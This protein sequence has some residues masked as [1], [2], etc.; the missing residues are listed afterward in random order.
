RL[1]DYTRGGGRPCGGGR[2]RIP[3]IS[4]EGVIPLTLQRHQELQHNNDTPERKEKNMLNRRFL[5]LAALLAV[6]LAMPVSSLFGGAAQRAEALPATIHPI[7]Y[8]IN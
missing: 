6:M 8:M 3:E 2:F 4:R 7:E 5:R 1:V